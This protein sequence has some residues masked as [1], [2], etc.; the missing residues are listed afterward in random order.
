MEQEKKQAEKKTLKIEQEKKKMEQEQSQY[1]ASTFIKNLRDSYEKRG[2]IKTN[3][4]ILM[5]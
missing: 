2:L 3:S 1:L 5:Q 4:L